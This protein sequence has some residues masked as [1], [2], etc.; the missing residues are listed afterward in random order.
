MSRSNWKGKYISRSVLRL[1][2]RRNPLKVWSRSSVIP[3]FLLK[4]TVFVYNGQSFKKVFVT[5]N[6]VG[7]KF[8]EF[9]F[10]RK[11]L[12]RLSNK[13]SGHKEKFKNK[14]K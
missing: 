13:K 9:A 6:R 14:K 4:K 5:R 8:G 7:Y 10:T 11:R 12:F 3:F 2:L 1:K